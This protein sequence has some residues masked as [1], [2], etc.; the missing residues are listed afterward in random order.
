[1]LLG[2]AYKTLYKSS[3][4]LGV[5]NNLVSYIG[6]TTYFGGLVL[7]L[8]NGLEL[9]KCFSQSRKFLQQNILLSVFYICT[10]ALF[11]WLTNSRQRNVTKYIKGEGLRNRQDIFS[12]VLIKRTKD[13]SL[14]L[15]YIQR[16]VQTR[17][18]L[19]WLSASSINAMVTSPVLSQS[20]DTPWASDAT[21]MN[22]RN[23]MSWTHYKS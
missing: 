12:H 7:K 9:L 14:H 13:K 2:S 18:G 15:R 4:K 11:H 20:H 19:M 3:R 1:M 16:N 17:Y 21:L 10:I 23:L 6:A 5:F 8:T 22:I